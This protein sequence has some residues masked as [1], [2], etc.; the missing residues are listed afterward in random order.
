MNR[1]FKAISAGIVLLMVL[2][3]ST[4]RQITYLTD[5]E[6][7][8]DYPAPAA[9]ELVVQ[10]GDR[11]GITV[12][13]ATPELA[14]PFNLYSEEGK[15][16]SYRVDEDGNID[17]PV[18]GTIAVSGATLSKVRNGIAAGIRENGFIK[19]PI[20]NVSLDNFNITIVG[21]V[22][23]KVIPVSDESINILQVIA[24]AGNITNRSNIKDVMVVRTENGLRRSYSVNLQ[25]KDLFDSPVF[26]LRQND[27]VYVKPQGTSLSTSGQTV[28]SFVGAGLS[29]VT[30][31][32]NFLLWSS[33]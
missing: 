32:T 2:S 20:V 26:Y 23:N 12:S 6:Y 14:A 7:N 29:L 5:M 13:C 18:L 11:L 21:Q 27:V 9:P 22:G 4:A 19:D 25:S 24:M 10:P 15:G 1:F 17:F 3:C 30:I 33:R 28:M 16:L 31:I 8:K